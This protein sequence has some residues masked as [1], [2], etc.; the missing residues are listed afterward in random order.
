[1]QI[2]DKGTKKT[3]CSTCMLVYRR[4]SFCNLSLKL[5]ETAISEGKTAFCSYDVK[6][7]EWLSVCFYVFSAGG[8][9]FEGLC[10][11]SSFRT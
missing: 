5:G 7:P 2:D 11:G 3:R 4:I 10:R 8:L 9:N 6:N 1:M